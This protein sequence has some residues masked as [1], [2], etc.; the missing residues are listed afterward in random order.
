MITVSA[1]VKRDSKQ[2]YKIQ[3]QTKTVWYNVKST[4]KTE[5]FRYGGILL[6]QIKGYWELYKTIQQTST[7]I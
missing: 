2:F 3:I 4:P 7:S 6:R 5:C 1:G